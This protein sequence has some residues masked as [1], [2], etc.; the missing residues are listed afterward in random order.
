[1]L[2]F[3]TVGKG[4]K[5][6]RSLLYP[7]AL[8]VLTS[9]GLLLTYVYYSLRS[10]DEITVAVS[11]RFALGVLRA[12]EAALA[13]LVRDYAWWDQTVD[14]VLIDL[15]PIWAAENIGAYLSESFG[16]SATL[17]LDPNNETIYAS[18]DD[19]RRSDFSLKSFD[20]DLSPLLDRARTSV[21]EDG[22]EALTLLAKIGADIHLVA[23]CAI[24]KEYFGR[25]IVPQGPFAILI[26]TQRLDAAFV[27]QL[28]TEYGFPGMSLTSGEAHDSGTSSVPLLRPNGAALAWISWHPTLPGSQLLHEILPIIAAGFLA[29][30]AFAAILIYRTQ[31]VA[32]EVERVARDL[33]RQNEALRKADAN[34]RLA[35]DSAERASAAKTRFLAAA[36]HDMRQ[37]IQALELFHTALIGRQNSEQQAEVLADMSRALASMSDLLNSLLSISKLDAGV[38]TPAPIDFPL[39]SLFLRMKSEFGVQA[40]AA[41]IALRIVTCAAHVHSD[42]SLLEIIIRNFLSNALR[43]NSCRKIVLGCRRRPGALRVEV[44]DNGSGIAEN[45]MAAIFEEFYQVKNADNEG[46]GGFGLGLAIAERMAR[47]L[48]HR[49][50]ANSVLEKGSQFFVE[51]P[52]STANRTTDRPLP[53][54]AGLAEELAGA[55]VVVVEDNELVLKSLR[56]LLE[57]WGMKAIMSTT[58]ESVQRQLAENGNDADLV[59]ADYR[60][61]GDDTGLLAIQ[62]VKETVGREIPGILL[63]GDTAPQILRDMESAGYHVMHKPLQATKLHH[64]MC[65]LLLNRRKSA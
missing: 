59:I 54:K 57:G 19:E 8:I 48:D 38:I 5:L 20:W 40:E 50:G 13:R 64:L 3:E 58:I 36:S 51:V 12:E 49:I 29:M 4:T 53:A 62:G 33:A 39:H 45:E 16:T 21:T 10:Q 17:V 2:N 27:E 35:K 65:N 42:P 14:K 30:A 61:T 46:G 47:L 24:T 25:P 23:A 22:P 1:M 41:D 56:L 6:R 60:L 34:M 43:S 18:V 31:M 63:T 26:L 11:E 44:W 28:G 15:D 9:V 7:V 55:T 32:D 37:P 52:L